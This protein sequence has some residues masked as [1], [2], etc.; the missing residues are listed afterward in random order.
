MH[1]FRGD[2]WRGHRKRNLLDRVAYGVFDGS[3]MKGSMNGFFF[4]EYMRGF[5]GEFVQNEMKALMRG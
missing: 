3:G 2:I 4:L 5:S 1:L